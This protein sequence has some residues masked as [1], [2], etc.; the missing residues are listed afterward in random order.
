MTVNFSINSERGK[1]W[2]N[3]K[4]CFGGV[5]HQNVK[6]TLIST[7][8]LKP[9]CVTVCWK[10]TPRRS[11]LALP[12]QLVASFYLRSC[13]L[14]CR[15]LWRTHERA[16]SSL[17]ARSQ[18]RCA[19]QSPAASS[20]NS[21]SASDSQLSFCSTL[22]LRVERFHVSAWESHGGPRRVLFSGARRSTWLQI[23][24]KT[25]PRIFFF[26]LKVGTEKRKCCDGSLWRSLL[27]L[28]RRRVYSTREKLNMRLISHRQ[29][30]REKKNDQ[31]VS[32]TCGFYCR[33]GGVIRFYSMEM[34]LMADGKHQSQNTE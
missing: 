20:C 3:V 23:W 30:H 4:L 24:N 5:M 17:E 1:K 34:T 15:A 2:Q 33:F 27:V 29:K 31:K 13:R 18:I 32:E 25:K 19:G 10:S 26:F 7:N 22:H 16:V 6:S 8:I 14:F 21:R 28:S 12:V 9:N 11:W